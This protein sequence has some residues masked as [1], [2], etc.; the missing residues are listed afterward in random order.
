MGNTN[1]SNRS[2]E[3]KTL[4]FENPNKYHPPT[5]DF[6]DL[7][8]KEQNEEI[9]KLRLDLAEL[10]RSRKKEYSAY[11]NEFDNSEKKALRLLGPEKTPKQVCSDAEK[12]IIECLQSN[13]KETL[14]CQDHIKEYIHCVR[15]NKCV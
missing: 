11:R 14:R 2:S 1:K 13:P 12:F 7:G 3:E 15:E 4:I 10:K 9:E 8:Q 5:D 6:K